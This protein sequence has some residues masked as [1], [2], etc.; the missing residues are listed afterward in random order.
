M[1]EIAADEDSQVYCFCRQVSFGDM[2]ACDNESCEKEWFHLP[3][4]GLENPPPPTGKWYC[5]E[6]TAKMAA[7]KQRQSE[8]KKV[9]K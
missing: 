6:C 1:D 5:S 8:K 9:I 2:I 3:C 4:V 7:Q